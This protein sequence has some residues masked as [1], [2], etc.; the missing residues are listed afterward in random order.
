MNYSSFV[1]IINSADAAEAV[2]SFVT[3]K[4]VGYFCFDVAGGSKE[5]EEFFQQ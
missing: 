2:E 4:Q 3:S 5:F 1:I